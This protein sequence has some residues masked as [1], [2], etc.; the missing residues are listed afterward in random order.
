MTRSRRALVLA[1]AFAASLA[2]T[3]CGEDEMADNTLSGDRV[4][5]MAEAQLEATHPDLARGSM[6]CA[7]LEFRIGATSRCTRTGYLSRGRIVR[8]LGTVEV[9]RTANEG[10]LHVELDDEVRSF[11]LAGTELATRIA[12]TSATSGLSCPDLEGV[13][14]ARVVCS[15]PAGTEVPVVATGVDRTTYEVEFELAR[16]ARPGS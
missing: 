2:A 9:T 1:A 10:M 7:D 15:D 3:G 8:V 5:R 13:V 11:A 4:A 6:V 12:G 14:G 16:G